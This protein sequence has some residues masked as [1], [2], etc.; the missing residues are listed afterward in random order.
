LKE[1]KLRQALEEQAIKDR[2]EEERQT[3][4]KADYKRWETECNVAFQDKASMTKF[5]F[6]PLPR[7]TNPNCFAFAK[8]PALACQHNV[9]QFLKGSGLFSLAFLKR[10]KNLWHE[11]RFASCREDLRPEFQRLANSLFIILHP[12]YEELERKEAERY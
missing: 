9:K 3:K 1:A 7:C 4:A 8:I 11:D 6:P 2:E 12:W 5:P 10:Q